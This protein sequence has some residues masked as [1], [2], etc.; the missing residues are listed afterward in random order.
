MGVMTLKRECEKAFHY[1]A[2]LGTA[3]L[4]KGFLVHFNY[5]LALMTNLPYMIPTAGK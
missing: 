4:I 5:S 1:K 3:K 2:M